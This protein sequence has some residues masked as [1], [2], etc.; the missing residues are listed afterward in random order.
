MIYLKGTLLLSQQLLLS[1]HFSFCT[2]FQTTLLLPL[3]L[4]SGPKIVFRF[5]PF[6]LLSGTLLPLLNGQD[7]KKPAVIRH[8]WLFNL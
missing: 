5:Q 8:N 6:S 1:Y 3:L 2:F 4:L 7:T